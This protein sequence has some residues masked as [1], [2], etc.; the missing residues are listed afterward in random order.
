MQNC[1]TH[2][3][4]TAFLPLNVGVKQHGS[5]QVTFT[6]R[7]KTFYEIPSQYYINTLFGAYIHKRMGISIMTFQL[8]GTWKLITEGVSYADESIL[9][10]L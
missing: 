7:R 2:T 8:T 10:L 9:Y 4:I 6:G 5:S 3:S 1:G